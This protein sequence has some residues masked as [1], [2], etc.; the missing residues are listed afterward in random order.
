MVPLQKI[1]FPEG[2]NRGDMRAVRPFTLSRCPLQGDPSLFQ[3]RKQT[4]LVPVQC[5]LGFRT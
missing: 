5:Y 2:T 3:E 4:A 1:L